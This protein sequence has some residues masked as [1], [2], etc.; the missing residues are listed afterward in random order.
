MKIIIFLQFIYKIHGERYLKTVQG[1]PSGDSEGMAHHKIMTGDHRLMLED[2]RKQ[3]EVHIRETI[4]DHLRNCCIRAT[5][6]GTGLLEWQV[7]RR[8]IQYQPHGRSDDGDGELR[9]QERVNKSGDG[10][11]PPVP[12]GRLGY[13]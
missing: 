4:R 5:A 9:R 6:D 8:R 7:E 11:A 13:P 2:G 3:Q 12:R 10:T 1:P